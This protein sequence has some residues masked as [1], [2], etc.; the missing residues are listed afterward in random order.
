MVVNRFTKTDDL[1]NRKSAQNKSTVDIL[2]ALSIDKTFFF[3]KSILNDIS[4]S[5]AAMVMDFENF[6]YC[7]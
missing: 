6:N 7:A 3:L 5:K 2:E 4:N 1:W